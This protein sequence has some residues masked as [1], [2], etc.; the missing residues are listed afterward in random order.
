MIGEIGW[1]ISG[2]T[3]PRT[4]LEGVFHG[5]HRGIFR[6]ASEDRATHLYQNPYSAKGFTIDRLRSIIPS[7]TILIRSKPLLRTA[8]FNHAPR[9]YQMR[10]AKS[11]EV[12]RLNLVYRYS[13][14][15]SL[16]IS[17]KYVLYNLPITCRIWDV[18]TAKKTNPSPV[19]KKS[20]PSVNIS[21]RNS[22]LS[23]T[24]WFEAETKRSVKISSKI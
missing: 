12:R 19:S 3:K 16:N 23:R 7:Q 21:S 10:Q 24:V 1:G 4:D 20:N 18:R 8:L 9:S 15:L 2:E 17:E 5:F 22:K 6:Q 14:S 11:R 13:A